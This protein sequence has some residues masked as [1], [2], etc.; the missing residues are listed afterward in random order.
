MSFETPS[1]RPFANGALAVASR[2]PYGS[3]IVTKQG[4]LVRQPDLP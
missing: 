4:Q 2:E 1:T 3:T